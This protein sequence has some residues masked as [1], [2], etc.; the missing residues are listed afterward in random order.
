MQVRQ[1]SGARPRSAI[2]GKKEGSTG[3]FEDIPTMILV[4][5]TVVMF[6][7]LA[8]SI[9]QTSFKDRTSTSLGEEVMDFMVQLRGYSGLTHNGVEGLYDAHKVRGLSLENVTKDLWSNYDLENYEFSIAVL[10]VSGYHF[11]CSRSITT[12]QYNSTHYLE[13]GRA[14]VTTGVS[15]W[16]SDEEIHAARMEVAIWK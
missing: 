2:A 15:I 7:A 9:V 3:F 8:F 6:F 5:L 13:V 4:I 10:D 12:D 14:V 16:V 1:R 11:N